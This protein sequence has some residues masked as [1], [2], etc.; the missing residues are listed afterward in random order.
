MTSRWLT[1]QTGEREEQRGTSR[2]LLLAG[3][4][5][6]LVAAVFFGLLAW[7]V[8]ARWIQSLDEPVADS[9]TGVR[10]PPLTAL[11]LALNL[12]GVG[13]VVTPIRLLVAAYLALRR[14]A[15][16]LV[17]WI[18]MWVVSEVLVTLAKA[19]FQ[20]PRP[21]DG[22]VEATGFELPSGH[23]VSAGWMAFGLVLLLVPRGHRVW[24]LVGAT[25][26]VVAMALSRIYLSVHW[27]SGAFAGALLGAGIAFTVTSVIPAAEPEASSPADSADE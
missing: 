4:I 2:A 10:V 23:A 7:D 16:A 17:A 25:A 14:R 20:R 11:A 18:V 15:A 5:M 1:R 8:S 24:T 19:L 26:L 27:P 3:I 22:L 12:V 9:I 6:I 13:V 21:P